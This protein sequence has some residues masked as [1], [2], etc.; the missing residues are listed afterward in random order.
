MTMKRRTRMMGWIAGAAV[1]CLVAEAAV[2]AEIKPFEETAFEAAQAQDR[3]IVVE[4]MEQMCPPCRLQRTILDGFYGLP[5]FERLLVFQLDFRT[6][7]ELARKL[8]ANSQSLLIAF[9]GRNE[10]ARLVGETTPK[11]IGIFLRMTH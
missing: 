7:R 5:E 10:V 6:Q 2:A 8:K 9:K 11:Y 1:A 4:V 3:A